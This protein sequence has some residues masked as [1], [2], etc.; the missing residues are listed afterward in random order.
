M[1]RDEAILAQQ[2]RIQKEVSNIS[3]HQILGS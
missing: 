2:D 3:P 1:T